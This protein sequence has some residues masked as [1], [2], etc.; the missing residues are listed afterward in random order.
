MPGC[1]NI[2]R[3]RTVPASATS[4]IRKRRCSGYSRAGDARS[5]RRASTSA[6]RPVVEQ[7]AYDRLVRN[8]AIGQAA[9]ESEA[10][11]IIPMRPAD[12]MALGRAPHRLQPAGTIGWVGLP[13]EHAEFVDDDRVP[14]M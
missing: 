4:P 13:A 7:R 6:R 1:R 8:F 3:G 10:V 12:A 9:D 11:G 14:V 5:A 2:S